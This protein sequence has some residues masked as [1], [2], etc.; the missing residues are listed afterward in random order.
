[1]DWLCS[2]SQIMLSPSTP[3][4]YPRSSDN[5]S[6]Q[7]SPAMQV[8]NL[9]KV[10]DFN[11]LP[12]QTSGKRKRE[13]EAA[14]AAPLPRRQPGSQQGTQ[15]GDA[16]GSTAQQSEAQL[17]GVVSWCRE[18]IAWEQLSL[19]LQVQSPP[20]QSLQQKQEQNTEQQQETPG[21]TTTGNNRRE[22]QMNK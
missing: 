20:G 10:P 19:H 18:R 16:A 7:I 22:Q 17:S 1:M 2:M 15:A 6:G 4:Y 14:E 12:R 11:P 5:A 13:D 3:A 8:L 21:T 9:V